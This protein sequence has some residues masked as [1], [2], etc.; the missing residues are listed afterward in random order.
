MRPAKRLK[1]QLGIDKGI[2]TEVLRVLNLPTG[3]DART[4]EERAHRTLTARFPDSV[5]AKAEYGYAINVTREIYRT[6]TAPFIH[7]LLDE[8][9]VRFLDSGDLHPDIAA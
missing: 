1:H 7:R 5:V 6:E 4:E 3:H 8:I 2:T 9:E